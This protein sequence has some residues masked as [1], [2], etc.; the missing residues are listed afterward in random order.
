[1]SDRVSANTQQKRQP[2]PN[3]FNFCMNPT[4]SFLEYFGDEISGKPD[5][6]P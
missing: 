1:M 4:P 2:P 5:Q 6:L 3:L